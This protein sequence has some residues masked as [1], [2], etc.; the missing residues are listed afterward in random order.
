M[1]SLSGFKNSATLVS[2]LKP[3][4]FVIR[5]LALAFIIIA[6]ARPRTANISEETKSTRGIDIVLAIDISGSMLAKDL[7]PNRLEA[8]KKSSFVFC[9]K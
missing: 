5:L 9:R 7:Q 1:S 2:R 6:L 4:L 8:F 3:Y